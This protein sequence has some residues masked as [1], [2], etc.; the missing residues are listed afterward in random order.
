MAK[1]EILFGSLEFQSEALLCLLTTKQYPNIHICYVAFIRVVS[2]HLQV[3][4]VNF[5][6]EM[7]E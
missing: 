2:L 5:D 4:Y 7:K 3:L 6:E 1:P